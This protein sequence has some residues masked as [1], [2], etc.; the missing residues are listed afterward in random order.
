MLPAKIFQKIRFNVGQL[1]FETPYILKK[2]GQKAINPS[3]R[4][5]LNKLENRRHLN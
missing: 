3:I 4:I 2:H 5:Y 1:F